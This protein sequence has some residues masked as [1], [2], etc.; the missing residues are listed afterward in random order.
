M[1]DTSKNSER[2]GGG[3]GLERSAP[4]PDAAPGKSTFSGGRGGAWRQGTNA[5]LSGC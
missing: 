3:R 5:A 2:M 1:Y 4:A